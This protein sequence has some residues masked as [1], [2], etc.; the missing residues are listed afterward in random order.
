MYAKD[1]FGDPKA[2]SNCET[3]KD[4]T[5]QGLDEEG[6]HSDQHTSGIRDSLGLKSGL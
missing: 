6:P 3:I 4:F 1:C 5:E 2:Y